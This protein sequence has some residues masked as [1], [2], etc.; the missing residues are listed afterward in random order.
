MIIHWIDD[1]IMF[2]RIHQKQHGFWN[3]NII[4]TFKRFSTRWGIEQS[5]H[6]WARK[7]WNWNVPF[8]LFKPSFCTIT[9]KLSDSRSLKFVA[10]SS[11]TITVSEMKE[12]NIQ[13]L[14]LPHH[15]LNYP[16]FAKKFFTKWKDTLNFLRNRLTKPNVLLDM[17]R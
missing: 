3:H 14:F 10:F 9:R 5:Q 11:N 4:L 12:L 17:Y 15:F 8:Q 13:L 16:R 2:A 1:S 7:L 6:K